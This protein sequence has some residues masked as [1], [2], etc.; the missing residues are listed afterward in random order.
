MR[1]PKHEFF[2]RSYS[3][4]FMGP[5]RE[6]E[7]GEQAFHGKSSCNECQLH[8]QAPVMPKVGKDK[9]IFA[10][11]HEHLYRRLT[12]REC[13]RIQGFPDDFLFYYNNIND[14]YK[15]IGNAVPVNL[16]YEIAKKIKEALEENR[17]KN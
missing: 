13:A 15:M 17:G 7:L 12:V 5:N 10:K 3:T 8:P 9:N 2:S 11:G 14:G 6:R 1:I 16:S 4:N